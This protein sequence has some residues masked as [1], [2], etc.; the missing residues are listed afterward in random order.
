M[1]AGRRAAELARRSRHDPGARHAHRHEPVAPRA[2]DRERDRRGGRDRR[3]SR[4]TI[5]GARPTSGSPRASPSMS[6]RASARPRPRGW[7][8]ATPT[9]TGPTANAPPS[10]PT[11]SRRPGASSS[12]AGDDVVVVSHAGP[13]RIAIGLATGR[14]ARSGGPA[15]TGRRD[16]AAG[17][18]PR[19]SASRA[20]GGREG[21]LGQR[22]RRGR[23]LRPVAVGQRDPGRPEA[24]RPASPRPGPGSWPRPSRGRGRRARASSP[25]S[26]RRRRGNPCRRR[27][28]SRRRASRPSAPSRR[29]AARPAFVPSIPAPKWATRDAASIRDSVSSRTWPPNSAASSSMTVG[30][31]AGRRRGPGRRGRR[32]SRTA[33]PRRCPTASCRAC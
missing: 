9:S 6:S 30:P 1:P 17:D 7:R 32:A 3:A 12:Q 2:G 19:L 14:R 27:C 8:T 5:A 29:R 13:I 15:R 26:P 25:P 22:G 31:S 28:R 21:R 20:S 18:R 16:P 23:G 11:G 24:R 33:C 10:W 4:S